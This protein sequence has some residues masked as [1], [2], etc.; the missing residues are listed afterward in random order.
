MAITILIVDDNA[1][2]RAILREIVSEN[3]DLHVVGEAEDGA[4]AIRL[5]P[6]LRPAIM[7]LDFVMPRVNG[8]EV[9][10][11]LK[12]EHPEIKVI[13]VTVHTEDAYREAAEASGADAF[14]L[15]KMLGTVLLPTIQR[16]HGS[17]APLQAP[18]DSSQPGHGRRPCCEPS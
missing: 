11:W 13:I 15:K 16:L 18:Q 5:V 17:L 9:L 4:E 2:F 3:A 7:L 6:E 14:L 8:L 1:P 10:R 12:E